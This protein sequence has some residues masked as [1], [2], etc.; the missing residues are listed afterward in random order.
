ML[1][2]ISSVESM[3]DK[4]VVD[5]DDVESRLADAKSF[6]GCFVATVIVELVGVILGGWGNEDSAWWEGVMSVSVTGEMVVG[7]DG[8][9]SMSVDAESVESCL[10]VTVIVELVEVSFGGWLNLVDAW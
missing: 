6:E 8:V 4:I 10:D 9:E 2:E 5:G 3:L 7:T 1:D